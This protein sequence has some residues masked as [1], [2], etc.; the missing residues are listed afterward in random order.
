MS[1]IYL[2]V[3]SE[4]YELK[5]ILN[6]WGKRNFITNQRIDRGHDLYQIKVKQYDALKQD[7]QWR[8]ELTLDVYELLEKFYIE[9]KEKQDDQDKK[10]LPVSFSMLELKNS[11]QLFGQIKEEDII[12]IRQNRFILLANMLKE[13]FKIMSLHWH[14]LMTILVN[15]TKSF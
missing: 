5:N 8:H 7:I 12:T 11:N 4:I 14:T 9:Q 10:D 3:E 15:P 6:Y 13:D 2:D 1:L